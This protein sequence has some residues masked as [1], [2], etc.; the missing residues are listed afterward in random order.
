MVTERVDQISQSITVFRASGVAEMSGQSVERLMEIVLQ[1]RI[2][3]THVTE[4]LYEQTSEIR[5]QLG[6]VFDEEK[7]SL[8]VCLQ[9]LDQKLEECSVCIAD[10]RRLHLK[11]T[12]MH[13]KLV[14]LGAQPNGLPP[15]LPVQSI[16]E[17]IAWR[18]GELKNHSRL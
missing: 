9:A 11:L 10:Y 6:A 1:M 4:T 18:L 14:Q 8:E 17:I 16:E 13:H 3:L 7:H 15:P 12:N 2:N 5:E